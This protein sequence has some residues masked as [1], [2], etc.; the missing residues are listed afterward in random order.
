MEIFEKIRALRE[1]KQFSQEAIALELNL[2]QSQ[3]SRRE[4]GE[5]LF[6][7]E[8]IKKIAA[9]FDC[10]I[11]FLFDDQLPSSPNSLEIILDLKRE[12]IAQYE[13]RLQEKDELIQF[14]KKKVP[15]NP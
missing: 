9:I 3:Y 14:L 1:E 4:S 15:E 12:V 13:K 2:S 6:N 7:V 11:S 10:S 5:I 8:E